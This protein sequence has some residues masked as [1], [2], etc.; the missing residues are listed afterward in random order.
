MK[1][2][3]VGQKGGVGKTVLSRLL[4]NAILAKQDAVRVLLIDTD[5]QLSSAAYHHRAVAR[6]P[7]L[8]S[9]FVCWR[10]GTEEQLSQSLQNADEYGFD[11]VVIDTVGSHRDLTKYILVEADRAI[12]PFRPNL[13]EYESQLATL[14]LFEEVRAG[15]LEAGLDAP[16]VKLVLNDWSENQRMTADQKN[17]LARIF[18]EP[19]LADFYVPSR[20]GFDTLD[21]GYVLFKELDNPE[22]TSNPFVLK[23]RRDELAIAIDTLQKIE[24]MQ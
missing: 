20:N 8:E 24:Q 7:D 22:V 4:V 12:V 10:C 17:I 13:K 11:Y 16:I 14:Q 19:L 18:K 15:M 9:S 1:I 2:A 21:Q 23:S 5:P 3:L 6:Y